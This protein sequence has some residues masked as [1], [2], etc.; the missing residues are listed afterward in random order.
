MVTALKNYLISFFSLTWLT[1]AIFD[2]ELR[3]A[4]RHRRNYVLRFAYVSLLTF[5]LVLFWTVIIKNPG[6]PGSSVYTASRMSEAGKI[7]V[8]FIVWFQFCTGQLIA[9]VMLSNAISDE[10]YHKTLGVLMTTPISSF[11]IVMGKLLSRLLQ[12]ILLLAISLPLLAIVRI[13]GGVPW[14]Y[15]ISSLCITL[16]SVILIGSLSLFYSIFC[17][18]AYVVIIMVVFTLGFVFPMLPTLTMLFWMTTGLNNIIPENLI[19]GILFLPSPY[20]N[21]TMNM[22]AFLEP[23]ATAGGPF[24]IWPL[25]CGIILVVSGILLLL[26]M[27]FVRKVALRQATGQAIFLPEIGRSRK[28]TIEESKPSTTSIR[29]VTGPPVLW[30]EMRIPLLGRRKIMKIIGLII[31]FGL[32][33]LTYL[34][35]DKAKILREDDVQIAFV[36]L[37]FIMAVLNTIVIPATTITTEKESQTWP[38][39]LT[40]TIEDRDLLFGKFFGSL[41]RLL[42]VWAILFFH[43]AIFIYAGI[44][45]PMA[46]VQIGFIVVGIIVFLS[47]TGF[48]FSSRFKHTTTAVVM[49][50]VLAAVI[51]ALL[52]MSMALTGVIFEVHD[53]SLG[54]CID[55]HPFYQIVNIIQATVS[56]MNPHLSSALVSNTRLYDG[57]AFSN[58]DMLD[59]TA[60]LLICTVCYCLI[61]IFFIVAAR[62]RLR[63]HIF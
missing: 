63:K 61:G 23:R 13:F 44:I 51:W 46:F 47:C 24:F 32:L 55:I 7:I 11:Q 58:M 27:I 14:D 42:P 33:C 38:L 62:R 49:N 53:D 21:M 40:T 36:L 16:C 54:F 48:Y 43:L 1:G 19:T 9:C 10:I 12:L 2:K 6:S 3:V 57:V 56:N 37:F 4:S 59:Y 52:P 30:K 45:H 26:S 20:F 50:F 22:L 28:K 17:R 15:I 34:L 35:C 41:R 25:H 29:E 31:M 39:L 5:I 8:S 18:R 60:F